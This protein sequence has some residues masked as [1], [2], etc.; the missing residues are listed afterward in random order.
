MNQRA[1]P[2]SAVT[3]GTPRL[4]SLSTMLVLQSRAISQERFATAAATVVSDLAALLRCERV[5]LGLQEGGA[6]RVTAISGVRDLRARQDAVRAVAQAMQE[7]LDQRC[8]IVHPLP[9]DTAPGAMLAHAALARSNGNLAI[10]TMPILCGDR[11]AGAL[12]FE[13]RE[14][15]DAQTMQIAKDSALFIGPVLV[16]QRRAER[17]LRGRLAALTGNTRPAGT[18]HSPWKVATLIGAIALIV[19]SAWPTTYRVVATARVEG[20][21]QRV[22]A[23]PVDGYIQSVA[24]RPGETV[25]ANQVILQLEDR[26]LVLEREKLTSEIAILDKQYRDALSRDEAGPIVIAASKLDE[27]RAQLGLAQRQLERTALKAPF[28]GVLISGDLSQSIGMPVKRGQELMTLATER[29]Y[30]IVSEVDEQDVAVLRIG[31]TAQALFAALQDPV[32]FTVT[33]ISPLATTAEG[34]N[35]FEVEGSGAAGAATLR[36]GLRGVAK[37][38]VEPSFVA[39]VWWRRAGQWLRHTTWRLIG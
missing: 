6:V 28:D 17:S 23:A 9:P 27:A 24:T 31:Q 14:G 29:A 16:L 22:I 20:E 7:A 3:L 38:D 2:G 32:P 19:L 13:R 37:I 5:S 36:P 33:R 8:A 35:V 15:F 12:L 18:G 11:V 26:D 25:Q 21:V 30:R 39:A 1:S 34:R 4:N 10:C